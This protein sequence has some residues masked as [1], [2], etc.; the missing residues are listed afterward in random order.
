MEKQK[1][2]FVIAKRTEKTV[3]QGEVG[4]VIEIMSTEN[5][6]PAPVFSNRDV[7]EKF[8]TENDKYG[9][10]SVMEVEFE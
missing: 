5:G 8:R 6:M 3:G 4:Q 7:A 9:F 2:V 1:T 10:W